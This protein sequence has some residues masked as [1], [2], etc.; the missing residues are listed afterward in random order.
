MIHLGE[1]NA[2]D[3]APM[4]KGANHSVPT[5][6]IRPQS[7]LISLFDQLGPVLTILP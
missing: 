6:D 3:V 4:C 2:Q 5:Q 1:D 7:K